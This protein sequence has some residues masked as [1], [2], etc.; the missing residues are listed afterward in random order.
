MKY[1]SLTFLFFLS[2]LSFLSFNALSHG[3][4]SATANVE[5]RPG[6]LIELKVQF[7]LIKLLNHNSNQYSL[8]LIAA[9]PDE[10]FALFYQ[11]IIK[12]FDKRLMIK[13][14]GKP[15]SVNKRYPSQQQVAQLIKRQF[16]SS[17]LSTEQA[18]DPYTFSDR[19]YYQVFYFDFRLSSKQDLDNL[20][21][22]FPPELGNIYITLS[23]SSNHEVHSGEAWRLKR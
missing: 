11:E 12:L 1:I 6:N 19:R 5:V 18:T 14:A 17:R 10:K 8:A 16:I 20:S 21:V 4:K 23:H 7:D 22:V 2:F 9:L 15:V 3:V 13:S